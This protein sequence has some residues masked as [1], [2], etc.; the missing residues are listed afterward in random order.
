MMKSTSIKFK[1]QLTFGILLLVAGIWALASFVVSGQISRSMHQMEL[2]STLLRNQ[3]DTDMEHDAIRGDVLGILA[4]QTAPSLNAPELASSLKERVADFRKLYEGTLAYPDSPQVH[5][6]A[7][8]AKADVEMYLAYAEQIADGTMTGQPV[9]PDTLAQFTEKFEKLE[10]SL[11]AVSDSIEK[12]V[13]E[14]RA[15]AN[16]DA[17]HGIYVTVLCLLLIV[18]TILT[19]WRSFVAQ[20]LRPIFEIKGAVERLTQR[21][22]DIEIEAAGRAD[23]LGDLSIAVYGMR[24]WIAEALA[25]RKEQEQE[26]VRTLGAALERLASGDLSSRIETDLKG[27]F[28]SLRQD[29]NQ[30]VEQLSNALGSVH[31]STDRMLTSA[32]EISRSTSDLAHRNEEQ[33]NSLQSIAEAISNVSEKVASSAEAVKSAQSAVNDVNGAVTQGEAVIQRAVEAMDKIETSSRAIDS[34]ITV[35]DA[36]AFQTNLLALN[37]GVEAVR[38]GE[39]G[40]GFNVV[41]SEVRALAQ[42][43]AD[44]ASEIKQL[45]SNSSAQVGNGVHLVREAGASLQ[46]VLGKV[47]EI[48]ALMDGLT[49]NA[50][51]Q[52]GTLRTIDSS[53]QNIQGITQH[54][55]A[56]TEE[57]SAVT[58]KVVEVTREVVGQL[59]GFTLTE[60]ARIVAKRARAA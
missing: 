33:A 2:A 25:A 39:A 13:S 23:E 20:F 58:R 27:A 35:I 38:A 15:G 8:A 22:L 21:N 41:A 57:V 17:Q 43:S 55:A 16:A 5:N 46:S 4:A 51:E 32:E 10:G 56:A 40:K 28:S 54:N 48:A 6:S 52:A 31:H 7:A 12:H 29:F 50:T 30:A 1:V 60:T 9:S 59:S 26:I 24:D 49:E 14:T 45:I 42:R 19:V 11:A 53:A 37:A 44:A 3:T 36:I 18:G 34:I 47:A